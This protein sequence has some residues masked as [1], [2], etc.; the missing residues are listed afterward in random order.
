MCSVGLRPLGTSEEV[1]AMLALLD[2]NNVA[3]TPACLDKRLGVGLF[4]GYF[5][6]KRFRRKICSLDV[7][8][9]VCLVLIT[10]RLV[11]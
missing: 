3:Y 9:Y 6:R 1:P 2:T 11:I 10:Y 4:R 7:C 8:T 5:N